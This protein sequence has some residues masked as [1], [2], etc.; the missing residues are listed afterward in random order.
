MKRGSKFQYFL[1]DLAK[2]QTPLFHFLLFPSLLC[3]GGCT[4]CRTHTRFPPPAPTNHR[5]RPHALSFLSGHEAE[6]RFPVY[7]VGCSA[8][9]PLPLDTKDAGSAQGS[10]SGSGKNETDEEKERPEPCPDLA[11]RVLMPE[12]ETLV[13]AH[14]DGDGGGL[15]CTLSF[16]REE[17][18]EDW[19][20]FVV[21][22]A[23]GEEIAS[24]TLRAAV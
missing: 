20:S 17:G 18:R 1:L 9:V 23:G 5:S 10:G 13:P 6:G 21:G 7:E 15:A 2:F 19:L 11:P 22:G 4:V 24:L 12:L 14:G 16:G 3:L 8:L